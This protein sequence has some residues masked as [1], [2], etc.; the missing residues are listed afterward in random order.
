MACAARSTGFT[1]GSI[2]TTT[3]TTTPTIIRRKEHSNENLSLQTQ[4]LCHL[5]CS[6]GNC[7]LLR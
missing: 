2:L 3:A 7:L 5:H 6:V 4:I 1:A